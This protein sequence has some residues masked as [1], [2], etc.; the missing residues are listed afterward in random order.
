MRLIYTIIP[1]VLSHYRLKNEIYCIHSLLKFRATCLKIS[2]AMTL[3]SSDITSGEMTFGRLDWLPRLVVTTWSHFGWS[4]KEVWQ[5]CFTVQWSTVHT[6]LRVVSILHN[7][8]LPNTEAKHASAIYKRAARFSLRSDTSSE[9]RLL[10]FCGFESRF[11]R[12]EFPRQGKLAQ[13][14]GA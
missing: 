7:T 1:L 14:N 9:K 10:A 6:R 11:S 3:V 13:V 5:Y 2:G 8:N 4:I 12:L